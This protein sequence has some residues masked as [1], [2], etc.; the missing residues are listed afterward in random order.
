[1]KFVFDSNLSNKLKEL[2]NLKYRIDAYDGSGGYH[3][4]EP[5]EFSLDSNILYHLE[6]NVT[7]AGGIAKVYLVVSKGD[8]FGKPDLIL[9]SHPAMLEFENLPYGTQG[10]K[11]TVED[12]N[13]AVFSAKNSADA[14]NTA[15]EEILKIK[16]DIEELQESTEADANEVNEFK[17]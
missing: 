13:S 15:K 3:P 5:L 14:A 4:S 16:G 1:M 9:Y 10:E 8:G 2:E 6:Q 11:K 17:E 7:S 12:I